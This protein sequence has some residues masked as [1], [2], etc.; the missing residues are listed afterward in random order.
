MKD[1]FDDLLSFFWDHKVDAIAQIVKE[2]AW[3][4]FFDID[5]VWIFQSEQYLLNMISKV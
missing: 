2:I 4:I 1:K 3:S 5:H